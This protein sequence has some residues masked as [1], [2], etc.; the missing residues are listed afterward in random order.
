MTRPQQPDRVS[1]TVRISPKV[2]QRIASAVSE[3]QNSGESTLTKNALVERILLS[4][5][6]QLEKE[7]EVT[8]K[9]QLSLV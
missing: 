4:G 3:L 9:R 8:N 2:M 6:T 7:S 5:L 1:L